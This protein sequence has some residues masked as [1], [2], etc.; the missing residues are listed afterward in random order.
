MRLAIGILSLAAT[1][2]SSNA[3]LP[4]Q[5]QKCSALQPF[6]WPVFSSKQ[7]AVEVLNDLMEGDLVTYSLDHSGEESSDFE[8]GL[9]AIIDTGDVQ[10][11]C[12]WSLGCKEYLWDVEM[13]LVSASRIVRL[14]DMDGVFVEQR[15][16]SRTVDPHGE[17]S[18]D[19]YILT[20]TLDPCIFVAVRPERESNW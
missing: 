5:V 16:A 17:H 18:E 19:A 10:P 13:D 20:K 4:R 12:T 6:P 7:L 8:E 9:G 15:K 3:L 14:L 1:P 2:Q 11:L